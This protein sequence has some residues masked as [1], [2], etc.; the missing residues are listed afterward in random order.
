[1]RTR[2]AAL[3]AAL[4]TTATAAA[5]AAPAGATGP[6]YTSTTVA[7]G[8]DNPRGITIGANGRAYVTEAGLGAGNATVGVA[9]GLGN[10][11]SILEIR[12]PGGSSFSSR[13][14]IG[15]LPSAAS[16]EGQGPEAIGP[17][18]IYAGGSAGN[19]KLR[20]IVGASG[21][22]HTLYGH[23]VGIRV[24]DPKVTNLGNVGRTNLAWTALHQHD[25]W[26]PAGQFPDSNPYGIGH[27][28]GVRYVVDAGANTLNRVNDDGTVDI[29]AYF[30]N[31]PISDAV[32]TC[33]TEGPDEAL[34]IGTL[35]LAD[36]FASGPGTATVYRVDPAKTDPT[37]LTRVLNVAKPWATGFSTITGCTFDSHGNFYATE[38]FTGDV[39]KVPFSHPAS[40]T[41]IGHGVLTLPNGVA[42][43]DSGKVYVTNMSDSV[44]AGAGSVV[45]FTPAS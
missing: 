41:T 37:S 23:A 9:N 25:P 14:L 13:T 19:V 21:I 15:G 20:V 2:G 29:L 31:T 17:D 4:L 30:P 18:G 3:A 22:P 44:K 10:T 32:P 40:R 34:Y 26:A 33:V 12:R 6:G 28:G 8:L 24:N 7:T 38:M 45:R 1:M 27:A 5:V 39:V 16:D 43:S 35:A 42:V 11:G 36:F